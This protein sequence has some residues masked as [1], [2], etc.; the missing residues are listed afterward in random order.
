MGE[1]SKKVIS[2][3][4]ENDDEE[5]IRQMSGLSATSEGLLRESDSH[6]V[7]LPPR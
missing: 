3:F 7:K 5:K 2:K 1:M 6:T 4:V